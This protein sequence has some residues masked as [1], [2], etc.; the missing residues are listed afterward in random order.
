MEKPSRKI[1][2]ASMAAFATT[3]LVWIV[4]Q[5][6]VELPAE[7]AAAVTGLLTALVGYVVPNAE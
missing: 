3:I 6:G 2:A 5:C 4:G 7:V 1:G